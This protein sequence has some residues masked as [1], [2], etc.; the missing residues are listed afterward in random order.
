[1][2]RIYLE[3]ETF[4]ECVNAYAYIYIY[5]ECIKEKGRFLGDCEGLKRYNGD[6]PMTTL[7]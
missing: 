3:S 4:K 5:R 2:K 1:M 6:W 7:F